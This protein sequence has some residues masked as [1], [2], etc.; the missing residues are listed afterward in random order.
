M[1][2][3]SPL[4]AASHVD[5][6]VSHFTASL[7]EIFDRLAPIICRRVSHPLTPWLNGAIRRLIELKRRALLTY[8][9]SQFPA[10]WQRYKN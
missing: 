8:R 2:D 5:E 10:D 6:M 9:R 4:Y 7:I 1:I 3:W